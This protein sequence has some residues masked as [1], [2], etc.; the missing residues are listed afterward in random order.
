MHNGSHGALRVQQSNKEEPNQVILDSS[1]R[2]AF[3]IHDKETYKF[4]KSS[5]TLEKGHIKIAVR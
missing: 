5:W 1:A 2:S 4:G 3:E